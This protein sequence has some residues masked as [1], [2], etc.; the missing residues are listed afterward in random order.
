MKRSKVAVPLW[1]GKRCGSKFDSHSTK[2]LYLNYFNFRIV[3]SALIRFPLRGIKY[4]I[5]SFLALV[6]RKVRR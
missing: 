5:F 1:Y 2:L 3:V 6:T 4:L